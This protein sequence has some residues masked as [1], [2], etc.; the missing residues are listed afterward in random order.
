MR[1]RLENSGTFLNEATR[2]LIL[3]YMDASRCQGRCS[4]LTGRLQF[5]IRP[6]CAGLSHLRALMESA[7]PHLICRPSS[8]L[9]SRFRFCEP[10]S[11]LFAITPC[12]ALRNFQPL[13]PVRCQP[14]LARLA[15][16]VPLI[17]SIMGQQGP[18]DARR[19]VGQGHR[20]NVCRPPLRHAPGPGRRRLAVGE[21]RAGTVDQ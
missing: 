6:V 7:D 13:P 21:Y 20:R 16:Q 2:T 9:E 15:D 4:G 1:Q 5:Y 12:R 17:R 10:R 8:K 3:I 14:N 19:L 18:D 11:D